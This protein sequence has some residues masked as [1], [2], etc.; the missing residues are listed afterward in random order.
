M[1]GIWCIGGGCRNGT[2]SH[3]IMLE[4]GFPGMFFQPSLAGF[5]G[6]GLGKSTMLGWSYKWGEIGAW[7]GF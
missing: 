4:G 7:G 6:G 5:L 3:R 1:W 2:L